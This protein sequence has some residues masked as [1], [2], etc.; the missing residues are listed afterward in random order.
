MKIFPLKAGGMF[1]FI[2]ITLHCHHPWS[3]IDIQCI[4]SIPVY[5][6]ILRN[7]HDSTKGDII[8]LFEQMKENGG[9][10]YL[11]DLPRVTVLITAPVRSPVLY[12]MHQFPKLTAFDKSCLQKES[13]NFSSCPLT[14]SQHKS[15]QKVL[16][17]NTKRI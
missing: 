3:F 13:L 17:K 4:T 5:I 10:G 15:N 8:I 9:Q 7:S 6:H 16:I 11:C 14:Y 12:T 1:L 2:V